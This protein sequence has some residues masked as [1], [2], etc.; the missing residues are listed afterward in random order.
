MSLLRCISR[1]STAHKQ[2]ARPTI[3]GVYRMYNPLHATWTPVHRDEETELDIFRS[4][5]GDIQG[6]GLTT[7]EALL[8]E[9]GDTAAMVAAKQQL[10]HDAIKAMDAAGAVAERALCKC[11]AVGRAEATREEALRQCFELET[12]LTAAEARARLEAK[13]ARGLPNVMARMRTLGIEEQVSEEEA[14]AEL[15]RN[16]GHVG[17]SINRFKEKYANEQRRTKTVRPGRARRASPLSFSRCSI[18]AF[19]RSNRSAHR[20][21]QVRGPQRESAVFGA[22][23]FILDLVKTGDDEES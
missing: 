11:M 8:P 19:C 10:A 22:P 12:L 21:P 17:V 14:R 18:S 23:R 20:L 16:E 3:L 7:E 15:R 4:M 6:L 9:L 5:L 1:A 2:P 13:V